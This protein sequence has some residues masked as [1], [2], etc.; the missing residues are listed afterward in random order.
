MRRELASTALISI[1]VLTTSCSDCQS[2]CPPLEEISDDAKLMALYLSNEIYP[3]LELSWHIQQDLDYIRSVYGDDHP[4]LTE[5]RFKPRWEL[6]CLHVV[7]TEGTAHQIE[8]GEYHAWDDLNEAY[9]VTEMRYSLGGTE[10]YISFHFAH[11]VNPVR[12]AEE[13]DALP[14]TIYAR[15]CMLLGDGSNIY[16][17]RTE[18]GI[19]YLFRRGWG[20]CLMGCVWSEY[21]YFRRGERPP[22]Y[23]GHW[24]QEED[25]TEPK[26]WAEAEH[27][28][29]QFKSSWPT[30]RTVG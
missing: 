22:A 23:E 16:P 14:G 15:P 11:L 8:R 25:Q 30:G 27:N 18:A 21:W 28:E 9:G 29:R 24:N 20:D 17:L 12:L 26:W 13:Y 19:T 1:L 6:N 2:T 4:T 7:F 10:S 5:L 3:P